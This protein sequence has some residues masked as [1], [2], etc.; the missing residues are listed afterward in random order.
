MTSSCTYQPLYILL[1]LDLLC[2]QRPS[3]SYTGGLASDVLT[4]RRGLF[5]RL[6]S[7]GRLCIYLFIFTLL[8][9]LLALLA[10]PGQVPPERECFVVS[11]SRKGCQDSRTAGSAADLLCSLMWVISSLCSQVGEYLFQKDATIF[12]VLW[13]ALRLQAKRC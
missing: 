3:F 6:F 12:H 2:L 1:T 13:N 5:V 11:R 8:S 7:G 9:W 10:S 4:V